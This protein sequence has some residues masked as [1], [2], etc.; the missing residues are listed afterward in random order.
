MSNSS[1]REYHVSP[2][3]DDSNDGIESSPLRTVQRGAE[4][5]QAGDVVT[6]HAG[7]YREWINPPRGG[8]SD[9]DRIVFQAAHGE[10]AIVK[11]SEPVS[12]WSRVEGGAWRV[13]LPND[14][15][16]DFNPFAELIHGDWFHAVN[17][18]PHL[19]EVYLDGR[20]LYEKPCVDDVLNPFPIVT[21][22][23]PEG[24]TGFWYAEVSDAETILWAHFGESDP[25]QELVEVNVRRAC[26][27]PSA[28]G[29]NYL[30]IRG[31]EMCQAATQ[32]AAPTAEQVGMI[33][34]HWNKGWIIED[35][36]LH[37]SKCNAITLGKERSTGHNLWSENP[38]K[39]GSIHYID[40]IFSALRAG[41]SKENIG[42]HIVR[43]NRISHCEQ[44]GICGSMGCAFS[45]ISD[46]EISDIWVKQQFCGAEIAAIKFH[47][48]IDTLIAN[49]RL[50]HS[51]RGL[52]LDWMTQGT[53][54]TGNLFHDNVFED[55]YVEVNHGPFVVD[56]NLFL[57]RGV[58]LKDESQGGAYLHNIFGGTITAATGP[59]FTPYHF[60][61]STEVAGM[62]VIELSDNRFFNNLFLGG[63]VRSM[64]LSERYTRSGV[65]RYAKD[66]N[67]IICGGNTYYHGAE[68]LPDD[69]G[70]VCRFSH[71]PRWSLEEGE[72]GWHFSVLVEDEFLSQ[73]RKLVTTERLGI[74]KTSNL[75]FENFDGA[76]LTIDQDF[77]SKKRNDANPMGGAIED[78]KAGE[79]RIKVWPR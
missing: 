69:D 52:W 72:D 79:N 55:L 58:N 66:A 12:G 38:S 75:G 30:T 18:T 26:F 24:T 27:Y 7:V 10:K 34:T 16:G 40:V 60:P 48:P 65:A 5:A 70:S 59:R 77:L 13:S 6:V 15:F 57:T 71:D 2:I 23:D 3:G 74:T 17:R 49:N 36:V 31:F 8:E 51:M 9:A 47:G 73:K 25:N 29:I 46:N 68:G 54:V 37:N 53:R 39:C 33:S 76:T 4:L 44:T 11:G 62:A 67:P 41:W 32:W 43:R 35:N 78:L 61:H 45:E 63:E 50:S 20:S 19:G 14:F 28:P 21:A 64:E 42:S 22:A 1:N 56:N